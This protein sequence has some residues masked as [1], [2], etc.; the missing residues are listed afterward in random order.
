MKIK[1]S[2]AKKPE[3]KLLITTETIRLDAAL[4]LSG[5]VMTGGQAKNVIQEGLVKVG[6]EVCCARGRKLAEGDF[7]EFERTIYHIVR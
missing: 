5:A 2:I 6:G 7:F 4:K 3:K 1:V